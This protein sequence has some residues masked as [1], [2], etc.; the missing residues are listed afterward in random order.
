MQPGRRRISG[1]VISMQRDAGNDEADTNHLG[2][3]RDLS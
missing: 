3:M 1:R 2:G